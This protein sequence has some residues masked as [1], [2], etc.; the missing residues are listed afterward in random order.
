MKN[1]LLFYNNNNNYITNNFFLHYKKNVSF[2]AMIEK[3]FLI[4]QQ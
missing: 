4:H 2:I 3:M 1:Y